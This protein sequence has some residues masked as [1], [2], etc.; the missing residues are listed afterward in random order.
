[1]NL[2]EVKDRVRELFAIGDRRHTEQG[3][4]GVVHLNEL[5]TPEEQTELSSLLM[6]IPS[7]K[8]TD[9]NLVTSA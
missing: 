4:T 8:P 2:D 7:K 3:R 1:M 5:L 6:Q 9:A